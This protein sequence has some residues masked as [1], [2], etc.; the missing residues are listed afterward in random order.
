[1]PPTPP[2]PTPRP[3]P[4]PPSPMPPTP[5][6]PPTPPPPQCVV[7][8][9]TNQCTCPEDF[10]KIVPTWSNDCCAANV[11]SMTCPKPEE[12][13]K[14]GSSCCIPKGLLDDTPPPLSPPPSPPLPC[15]FE[16]GVWDCVSNCHSIDPDQ[17]TDCKVKCKL[18]PQP[19]LPP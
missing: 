18:C 6:P 10:G 16:T 7:N 8:D 19:P 4:P 5:M 17:K 1:M 14:V 11:G 3:T 15:I 12:F 9:P 13:P 2:P